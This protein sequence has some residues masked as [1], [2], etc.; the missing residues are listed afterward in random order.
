VTT[1][2][3]SFDADALRIVGAAGPDIVVLACDPAEDDHLQ[4]ISL[5][6]QE[7][8][9]H[10]LVLDTN[11]AAAGAAA[12]LDAGADTVLSAFAAAPLVRATIAAMLR[13][14]RQAV[15]PV[16]WP[17]ELKPVVGTL[18][19]DSD[20][21]E[22]RDAGELLHLTPTE[23]KI[24]AHLALHVGLVRSPSQIMAALH[25]YS[26][27]ELE[28]RQTVRVYIRRIR[29]KLAASEV[30]SVEVVSYRGRGYRIEPTGILEPTRQDPSEHG[31]GPELRPRLVG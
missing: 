16:P 11:E 27:G 20:T 4:A 26:V 9:W 29:T 10:L 31:G 24:V 17:K 2:V 19:V 6:A 23:F 14:L 22:V 21:F 12:A 18:T 3:R 5:L 8:S 13:R 7:N 28:A 15:H 30:A 1:V 25:D